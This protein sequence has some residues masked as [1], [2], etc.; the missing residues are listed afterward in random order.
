MHVIEKF[1][2]HVNA[3]PN[4][5]ATQKCVIRLVGIYGETGLE[6]WASS[7]SED[8]AELVLFA[9]RKLGLS[10]EDAVV[11]AVAEA[12]ETHAL[13]D[14]DDPDAYDE[15][16]ERLDAQFETGVV[17]LVDAMVRHWSRLGPAAAKR[18]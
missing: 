6:A 8:E 13:G 18:A 9:L 15:A 11:A 5:S 12:I 2:A 1:Q 4:P 17:G 16:F 7:T 14:D 10:A 3:S